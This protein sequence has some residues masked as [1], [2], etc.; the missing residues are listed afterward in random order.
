MRTLLSF[1]VVI[2]FCSA[3]QA[4]EMTKTDVCTYCDLTEVKQRGLTFAQ[5]QL[6][7]L[8]VGDKI[9]YHSL[10]LST[11]QTTTLSIKVIEVPHL[12]TTQKVTIANV[13]ETPQPIK[14]KASEL[15]IAVA[16][17]ESVSGDITIPETVVSH[18][19]EWVNCAYCE[20][21]VHDFIT[22]QSNLTGIL[23]TIEE[24][25]RGLGLLKTSLPNTY[26]IP[27]QGGGKVRIK[28]TLDANTKLIIKIH[29]VID[30]NNN[31]V[32]LQVAGLGGLRIRVNGDAATI[33]YWINAFNMGIVDIPNGTVTITDCEAL[34]SCGEPGGN[35]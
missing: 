16:E 8:E 2:I 25:T 24:I 20:N 11:Y 3:L 28:I 4:K 21:D 35:D 7:N 31:N 9:N 32:P 1:L 10:D 23:Y 14:L 29:Q 13:V 6:A 34:P 26:E 15:K 5:S 27:M 12:Q 30:K 18:P 19:W 22:S 33:N 17:A